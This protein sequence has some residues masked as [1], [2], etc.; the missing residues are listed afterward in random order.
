MIF[1]ELYDYNKLNPTTGMDTMIVARRSTWCFQVMCDPNEKY[2][3][4]EKKYR[5][6]DENGNILNDVIK[7][8]HDVN[9]KNMQCIDWILASNKRLIAFKNFVDRVIYI[10]SKEYFKIRFSNAPS[11]YN[12]KQINI[13]D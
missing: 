11:I 5:L 1:R 6:L 2:K 8:M 3:D 10:Y 4:I 7:F 9:Q 12:C 13:E